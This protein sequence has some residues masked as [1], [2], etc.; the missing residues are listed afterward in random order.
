METGIP[1]VWI[2][3]LSDPAVRLAARAWGK[4]LPETWG[5]LSR[6][7]KAEDIS[8][9]MPLTQFDVYLNPEYSLPPIPPSSIPT[10]A[11]LPKKK[12]FDLQLLFVVGYFFFCIFIIVMG[13]VTSVTSISSPK[14]TSIPTPTFHIILG[15]RYETFSETAQADLTQTAQDNQIQALEEQDSAAP[16][17]IK[18][19]ISETTGEKIYHLPGQK[20]Y[21]STV[22]TPS[23]G[24]RWF[25][26]EAEAQTAGWRKSRQ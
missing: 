5:I 18:G 2:D 21:D 17:L 14:P 19:N 7:I 25:C 24:E 15:D 10:P 6:A 20:F 23:K 11:P 4:D 9:Y 3:I 13:V 8:Q 12:I 22:I 1:T 26:T 16:C